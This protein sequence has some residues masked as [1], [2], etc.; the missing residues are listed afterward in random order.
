M[1]LF[2]K[3]RK[4]IEASVLFASTLSVV[5]KQMDERCV[6]LYSPTVPADVSEGISKYIESYVALLIRLYFIEMV[7]AGSFRTSTVC[8]DESLEGI[9]DEGLKGIGGLKSLPTKGVCMIA[10]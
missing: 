2:R 4:L 10:F 6:H 1:S 3:R 5:W 7:T 8:H 9:C